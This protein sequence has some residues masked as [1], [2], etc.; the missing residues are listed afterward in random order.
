[1]SYNFGQY[2]RRQ[3]DEYSTSLDFV[4][5]TIK[6]ESPL[7]AAVVFNEKVIDLSGD[8]VLQFVDSTNTKRRNYYL[9]FKVYK[10]WD[11][12]QVITVKLVNTLKMTDNIQTLT[13]FTVDKGYES[14]YAVFDIVIPPNAIYNQ[15]QF[16]LNRI[17]DDYNQLNEDGTYG[18]IIN[19]EIDRLEEINNVVDIINSAIDN[20]GQ[21]KQIGVQGPP[22]LQM[23]I[24]GEGIKIGRSGLYE[25]NNGVVVR[26]IGFV[27]EPNDNKYFILDYQ[28]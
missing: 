19:I 9:K 26:F 1:M 20:K 13:T 21:L 24:D 6:E 3:S 10:M 8:N 23:C 22:G 2:R 7:S 18:R 4:L 16:F 12:A 27:V 25:I 5:D 14:D 28:Y 11:T 15:I 17:V